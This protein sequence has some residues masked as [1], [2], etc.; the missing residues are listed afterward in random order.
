M[1]L[2]FALYQASR[3][4]PDWNESRA[5][6]NL[7]TL[8]GSSSSHIYGVPTV[9]NSLNSIRYSAG[10]DHLAAEFTFWAGCTLTTEEFVAARAKAVTNWIWY[11]RAQQ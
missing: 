1:S 11:N 7:A 9:G 4:F 8:V 3:T 6:L 5:S 2:L 10:S